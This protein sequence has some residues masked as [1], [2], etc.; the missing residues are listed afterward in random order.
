MC[1]LETHIVFAEHIEPSFL[2]KNEGQRKQKQNI[3]ETYDV[4]V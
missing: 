4:V 2:T 1:E 3:E